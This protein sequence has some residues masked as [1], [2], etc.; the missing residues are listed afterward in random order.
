VGGWASEYCECSVCNVSG[1]AR[2]IDAD[3]NNS[4]GWQKN[5][6]KVKITMINRTKSK[7]KKG[8]SNRNNTRT[9]MQ[10]L[11]ISDSVKNLIKA[12]LQADPAK[13]PT[14]IALRH[15]KWLQK[16]DWKVATARGMQPPH[17]P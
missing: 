8:S 4:D 9:I 6:G 15:Q 16:S 2:I 13:R 7:G 5:L 17:V 1:T 10:V 12:C 3:N 11:K 14:V